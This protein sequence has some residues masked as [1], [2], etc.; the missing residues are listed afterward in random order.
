VVPERNYPSLAHFGGK[1]ADKIRVRPLGVER[2][3]VTSRNFGTQSRAFFRVAGRKTGENRWI[4][5]LYKGGRVTLGSVGGVLR[6]L[7]LE[8]TGLLFLALAVVGGGAT[9]REYHRYA[10]GTSGVGKV[11]LA[12]IF[13]VGFLYFGIGSFATSRRKSRK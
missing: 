7:W 8:V 1:S 3:K 6:V 11:L 2:K 5:A 4:R 13:A 12:A 10:A 9:V